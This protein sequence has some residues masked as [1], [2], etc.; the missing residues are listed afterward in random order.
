MALAATQSSGGYSIGAVARLTG[1]STH[2]LRIWER[3][4]STVVA[5][6]TDT[7]RRVYNREHVEKLSLLKLLV[8]QGFSIGQIAGLTL[9]EL[10]ERHDEVA[11]QVSAMQERASDRML[12]VAALARFSLNRLRQVNAPEQLDF[13]VIDNE[14]GRAHV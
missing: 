10:R 8:D 1:I 13:V 6:R 12:R 14:I 5:D 11:G 2:T 9:E 7:G 3:R 4:Y